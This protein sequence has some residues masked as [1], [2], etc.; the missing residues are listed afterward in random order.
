MAAIIETSVDDREI[1]SLLFKCFVLD[2]AIV[3]EIIHLQFNAGMEFF[4]TCY[5]V[6]LRLE[7]PSASKMVNSLICGISVFPH[8]TI[9]IQNRT[10]Y[11]TNPP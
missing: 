6:S 7:I 2:L 11:G 9:D 10:N 8:L 4:L 5:G 3:D 1:F